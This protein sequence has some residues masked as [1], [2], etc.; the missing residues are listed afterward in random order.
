MFILIYINITK[1][2]LTKYNQK[3]FVTIQRKK[4]ENSEKKT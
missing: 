1:S 2:L 3:S 4:I